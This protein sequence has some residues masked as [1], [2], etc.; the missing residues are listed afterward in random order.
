MAI[1]VTVS[2]ASQ[3][4]LAAKATRASF[5]IQNPPGSAGTI[6]INLDGT[7]ATATPPS[8]ALA[9]GET[10]SWVGIGPVTAIAATADTTITVVER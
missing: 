2:T 8:I 10:F 6:W 5:L 7:P 4:I 1:S 3:P 9:S